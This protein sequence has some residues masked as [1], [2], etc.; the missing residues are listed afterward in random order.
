MI[1]EKNYESEEEKL[2]IKG[3]VQFNESYI[4]L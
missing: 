3:T 1:E 4:H 2:S